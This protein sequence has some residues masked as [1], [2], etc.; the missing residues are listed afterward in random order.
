MTAALLRCRRHNPL[1]KLESSLEWDA[2]VMTQ[3]GRHVMEP[4]C[5][6]ALRLTLG[7]AAPA[8]SA[9]QGSKKFGLQHRHAAQ[10]LA[11]SIIPVKKV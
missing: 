9:A 11:L 1:V 6:A 10:Y 4:A 8:E 2:D 5:S 3:S 7:R